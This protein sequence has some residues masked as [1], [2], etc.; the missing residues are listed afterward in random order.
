MRR[1][2][3]HPDLPH[4]AKG[5]CRNCHRTKARR[6]ETPEQKAKKKVYMKAYHANRVAGLTADERRDLSLQ[7]RYGMTLE[8]FNRMVSDQ[9]GVCLLCPREARVVDHC[10]ETSRT[11][12]ILCYGCN[13]ALNRVEVPGWTEAAHKHIKG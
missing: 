6:N 4:Y 3:C 9:G 11:R 13:T 2:D 7:A 10:H 5:M 12:G 8:D 1:A